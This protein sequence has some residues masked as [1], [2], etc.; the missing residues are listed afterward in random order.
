[1]TATAKRTKAKSSGFSNQ[2]K[3]RMDELSKRVVSIER[4]AE[5][6]IRDVVKKTE[7][8]KADQKKRVQALLQEA[9]RMNSSTLQKRAERLRKDVEGVASDGLETLLKKLNLPTKKEYQRLNRK[10]TSLEKKL[11][12]QESSGSS[13]R[14]TASSRTKAGQ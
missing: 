4:N 13:A 12:E 9:R 1:M 5:K 7:K 10:V 6:Q 11:K 3:K 14:T 8:A 2:L